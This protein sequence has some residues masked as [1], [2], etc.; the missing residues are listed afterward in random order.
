M[1]NIRIYAG[2]K[3][4]FVN[5]INYY[6]FCCEDNDDIDAVYDILAENI[7]LNN[8]DNDLIDF[9]NLK[10]DDVKIMLQDAK[11]QGFISDY[12]IVEHEKRPAKNS[13]QV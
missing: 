4:S 7:K 13:E 1:M 3:A 2:K 10:D 6:D 12:E 5:G 8:P 11:K 9:E